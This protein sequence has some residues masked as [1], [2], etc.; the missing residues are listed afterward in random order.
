VKYYKPVLLQHFPISFGTTSRGQFSGRGKH[1]DQFES[2]ISGEIT[3]IADAAGSLIL[4]DGETL[5]DV[6][7]VHTH[8]VERICYSLINSDFSFNP[9]TSEERSSS[10]VEPVIYVTNTY[11]WYGEGYR[12]PILETSECYGTY[13]DS[14]MYHSR[15]TYFYHPAHQA[16]LPED[17]AN[18]EARERN[19]NARNAA[20]LENESNILS[21][22][23]YPNPVKN[24]LSIE[25]NLRQPV[26]VSA[27]LWDMNGQLIRQLPSKSD[28][29]HYL[30]TLDVSFC[31]P[32]YYL[33]KVVAG[34]ETVSE[35]VVKN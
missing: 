5:R 17:A 32:G 14:L 33:I 18:R 27:G 24:H 21:L 19:Q 8:K 1:H 15:E 6:I 4:P 9:P 13:I 29:T 16:N 10:A 7:R 12:Y 11:Q 20:M 25:V 35:R 28:T 2:T 22:Q 3:T 34:N 30:E 31:P 23:S 26:T